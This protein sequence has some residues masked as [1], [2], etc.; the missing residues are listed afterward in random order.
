MKNKTKFELVDALAM[1]LANPDTFEVPTKRE[2]KDLKIGDL[3]KVSDTKERFWCKVNKIDKDVLNVEVN[4][5]L[6]LSEELKYGDFI[7]ISTKNIYEIMKGNENK[8][9]RSLLNHLDNLLTLELHLDDDLLFIDDYATLSI[10]GDVLGLS[11]EV[12]TLPTLAGI[13]TKEV[14]DFCKGHT[15]EI[16]EAYAQVVDDEGVI[17]ELLFGDEAL[18]YFYTGELPSTEKVDPEKIADTLLDQIGKK[19]MNS[20][21]KDQKEFLNNFSKRKGK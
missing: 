17:T 20:L 15:V 8:L 18:H 3:V 12:N 16:F 1:A 19:G 13:I 11:F 2:I 6:I 10:E 14:I 4:N 21:S 7:D 9:F 5:E